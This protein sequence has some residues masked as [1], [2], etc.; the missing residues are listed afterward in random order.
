LQSKKKFLTMLVRDFTLHIE[1]SHAIPPFNPRD[2]PDF[3]KL[4]IRRVGFKVS[5]VMKIL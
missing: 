5:R 3:S 2:D 1:P 4:V